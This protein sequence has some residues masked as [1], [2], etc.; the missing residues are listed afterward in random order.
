MNRDFEIAK[1][2]L[3][4]LRRAVKDNK[5]AL[6]RLMMEHINGI[7]KAFFGPT[8]ETACNGEVMI[9][10]GYEIELGK[11]I[12]AFLEVE[13]KEGYRETAFVLKILSEAAEKVGQRRLEE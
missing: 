13:P 4:Q 12:D 7:F 10:Q 9:V 6:R 5:D 2:E 8:V 11:K 3:E 1:D